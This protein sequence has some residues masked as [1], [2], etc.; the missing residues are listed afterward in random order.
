MPSL[1]RLRSRRQASVAAAA[2]LLVLDA[3]VGTRSWPMPALGLLDES[4]HLLTAWLVLA[5]MPRRI[6]RGD[7]VRWALVGSVVINVDHL[8]MYLSTH[9]FAVQG[10]RPPTHS[11]VLVGAVLML[12]PVLRHRER[13]LGLA[14]GFVLHFCRDVATGPGVPLSWP[15]DDEHVRI[16]HA[17]YLLAMVLATAAIVVPRGTSPG[18]R[19]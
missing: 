5:A 4:A 11:L 9:D 6:P 10:A 19:P 13:A 12:A 16:P 18:G 1:T 2:G 17:V 15:I 7:F 8:P 14:A 3:A